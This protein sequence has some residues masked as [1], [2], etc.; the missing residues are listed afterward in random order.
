MSSPREKVEFVLEYRDRVQ[1]TDDVELRRARNVH[2]NGLEGKKSFFGGRLSI[3]DHRK[4][5]GF[6]GLLSQLRRPCWM[7]MEF[8]LY[9]EGSRPAGFREVRETKS[10]R[11]D[12]KDDAEKEVDNEG[13]GEDSAS[14]ETHKKREG[15]WEVA[16]VTNRSDVCN[17][18]LIGSS[19]L[20]SLATNIFSHACPMIQRQ[21]HMNCSVSLPMPPTRTF[22]RPTGSS[23]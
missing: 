13:E 7:C 6:Q 11:A 8:C 20:N 5:D 2:Q 17:G 15:E 19:H 3:H 22:A 21:I 4:G 14:Y 10:S 9:I 23:P 1:R 16:T 18:R 12:E